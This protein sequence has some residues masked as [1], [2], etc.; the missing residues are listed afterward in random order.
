M[1]MA[2]LT[3]DSIDIKA[4]IADVEKQIND[5]ECMSAAAKAAVRLLLLV[6][7][8]LVQRLGLNSRNSSVPPSRDPNRERKPKKAAARSPGGQPGSNGATLMPIEQPDQIQKLKIDRRTLPRDEYRPAGYERRQ[9]FE[10]RIERH[11]IEY[12]AEVLENAKGQRFVAPFP[13]GVTRP[14]QYGASVKAHAVYMSMFQLV[15]YER[16]QT[17]FEEQFG[18]PLS[19][20]SLSNFNREAHDRL[21]AFEA[22]AKRMLIA[23]EALHADETG[24]NVGGK[25]LWLHNAS[26]SNW[27]LFAPHEKRGQEAMDAMGILPDF[28][29]TLVHDHWKPYYRYDC[30]HALCNA[31]HLRELTHAHEED[32]QQWAKDMQ[33]LLLACN[34][35]VQAAGGALSARAAGTWRRRYRQVLRRGDI[36]C[37]PPDEG[38]SAKRGRVKRSKSRNLLERL[39]G[40]EEDVLR[41]MV[42]VNVPFTNNQGERDIRMTKVQQ[43]ISGC[44]RTMEGAQTFC[45]IRSYISTCQKNAVPVG[46][47]ID[48]LFREKWPEFIKKLMDEEAEGA[49]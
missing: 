32:G 16:V 11:V 46:D 9:V 37:P 28:H 19:T 17:H 2:K 14:A 36:E 1:L 29:G 40:F 7:H 31:H 4:T 5:D 49:E 48:L 35:A 6:V 43:K 3:L 27:T 41:F 47:A 8:L 24:I 12:Q 26:S 38:A 20:G 39:R 22:L 33:T 44:F 13:P 45:R 25:R 15:P 23:A 21:T 34:E 42:D 30:A 10:L 18:L